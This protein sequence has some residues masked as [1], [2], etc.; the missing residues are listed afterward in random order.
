MRQ[1]FKRRLNDIE[2]FGYMHTYDNVL[3]IRDHIYSVFLDYE[4]FI[5]FL[6]MAF[7]K[8]D[9]DYTPDEADRQS[10]NLFY[11]ITENVI[12]KKITREPLLTFVNKYCTDENARRYTIHSII[13]S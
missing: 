5:E 8:I 12:D 7:V 2:T 1:E 9:F 6:G 3:K 13:C 10:D 11:V 4:D